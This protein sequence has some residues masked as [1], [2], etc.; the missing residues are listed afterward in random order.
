MDITFAPSIANL[1]LN[2]GKDPSEGGD[3]QETALPKGRPGAPPGEAFPGW[4]ARRG[5]RLCSGA[6]FK[7]AACPAPGAT[8]LW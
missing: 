7:G 4:A 3:G 6:S 2:K 8:A 1:F 5:Q